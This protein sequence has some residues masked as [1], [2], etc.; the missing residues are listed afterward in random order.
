[1]LKQALISGKIDL[2]QCTRG[3]PDLIIEL[4]S[5]AAVY[6][7]IEI[8][9]ETLD[10]TNHLLTFILNNYFI[11]IPNM[12]I[13]IVD[14][15]THG[16]LSL[17]Q[18]VER[19][20]FPSSIEEEIINL[21]LEHSKLPEVKEMDEK[22]RAITSLR[23]RAHQSVPPSIASAEKES[24]NR[25]LI[26]KKYLELLTMFSSND[27]SEHPLAKDL[28]RV[29]IH[30]YA[31]DKSES[32]KK[33]MACIR[34]FVNKKVAV[35]KEERTPLLVMSILHCET[36]DDLDFLKNL[37]AMWKTG[38]Y[39]NEAYRAQGHH[40]LPLSSFA[41]MNQTSYAVEIFG[42][43]REYGASVHS[44]TASGATPYPLVR[45]YVPQLTALHTAFACSS[46][47]QTCG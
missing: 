26:E 20:A 15:K 43:L 47:S 28:L 13:K 42:L 40:Y 33:L 24:I 2:V 44:K 1:M 41:F 6:F 32:D 23:R 22:T 29:L 9:D 38:A 30:R 36:K 46:S 12:R 34:G 16:T 14:I 35:M 18:Y 27:L 11:N 10:G 19:M 7:Y 5:D 25:L 17:R 37:L 31:D 3:N 4:I 45:T 8:K 21:L 39:I